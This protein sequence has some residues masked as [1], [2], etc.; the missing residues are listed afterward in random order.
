LCG[1]FA[2]ASSPTRNARPLPTAEVIA[3]GRGH[4]ELEVSVVDPGVDPTGK[5]AHV[6]SA[7]GTFHRDRRPAVTGELV[8]WSGLR[9][10]WDRL[11]RLAARFSCPIGFDGPGRDRTCDLGIKSPARQHAAGCSELKDAANRADHRCSKQQRAAS[12]GDKRLRA[13]YARPLALWTTSS[14]LGRPRRRRRSLSEGGANT[15]S[16]PTGPAAVAGELCVDGAG[17]QVEVAQVR[18]RRCVD[19][20]TEGEAHRKSRSTST[21]SRKTSA[22]SASTGASVSTT[23]PTT[24]TSEGEFQASERLRDAALVIEKHPTALRLRYLQTLL[25]LGGSQSTTIV[26]PVPIDV[27]RPFLGRTDHATSNGA[28][29]PA[30]LARSGRLRVRGVSRRPRSPCPGRFPPPPPPP[31]ARPCS[32]GSQVL[33]ACPTHPSAPNTVLENGATE[34][35]LTGAGI[36]APNLIAQPEQADQQAKRSIRHPQPARTTPPHRLRS[37]RGRPAGRPRAGQPDRGGC[38]RSGCSSVSRR[39]RRTCARR[40]AAI[41]AR[42]GVGLRR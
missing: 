31:F 10:L 9:R 2:E 17:D 38:R 26:F 15:V 35:D 5:L 14:E 23:P 11:G 12:N 40:P 36:C 1:A 37:R 8:V 29:D 16:R 6:I 13:L 27:V 19:V 25:E 30:R 3:L 39:R 20:M 42:L 4:F 24:S 18:D 34:R 32:A 21:R 22:G 41:A 33:P 28:R 7:R